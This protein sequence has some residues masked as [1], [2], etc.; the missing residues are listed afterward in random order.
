MTRDRDGWLSPV[1]LQPEQ[2]DTVATEPNRRASDKGFLPV[3]LSEYLRRLDWTRRQS[4]PDQRGQIPGELA[5]L[6]LQLSAE[7]WV[8]TVLSFGRWFP[9]AA[10]RAQSLT[11][12][13][14][15]RRRHGLHGLSHSRVAFA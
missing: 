9:R 13:A 15:R 5:P 14:A 10:G 2:K 4:R 8:D 11:A 3:S 6:L 1:E 12:E 7:A